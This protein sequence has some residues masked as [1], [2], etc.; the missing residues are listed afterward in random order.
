M[1]FFSFQEFIICTLSIA[2]MSTLFILSL[3]PYI[4]YESFLLH[5]NF[6]IDK[7]LKIKVLGKY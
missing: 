1:N 2:I 6:F 7:D 4:F 3:L 5:K